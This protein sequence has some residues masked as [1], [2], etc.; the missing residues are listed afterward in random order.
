MATAYDNQIQPRR[1]GEAGPGV[2]VG[3]GSAGS[4]VSG[5]V[6]T[7]IGGIGN[8][9][10]GTLTQAAG[11]LLGT[12]LGQLLLDLGV[13]GQIANAFTT[14]FAPPNLWAGAGPALRPGLEVSAYT[15]AILG[16]PFDIGGLGGGFLG[17]GPYLGEAG[18]VAGALLKS[19]RINLEQLLT[20]GKSSLLVG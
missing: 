4:G 12:Y 15:S 16:Q 17:S 2:D 9:I 19:K 11:N 8:I 6:D 13:P 7:L 20:G 14:S 3:G 18:K 10:T 1:F 5:V